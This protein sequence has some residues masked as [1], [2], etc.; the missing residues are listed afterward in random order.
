ML[1]KENLNWAILGTGVVANQMAQAL[2]KANNQYMQWELELIIKQ[3][4][5]QKN[6]M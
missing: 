6:I 5:L 3:L 1:G 2:I 4:I